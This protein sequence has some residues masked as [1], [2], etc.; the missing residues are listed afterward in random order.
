[1]VNDSTS[2]F[3]IHRVRVSAPEKRWS[4]RKDYQNSCESPA[5]W[6]PRVDASGPPRTTAEFPTQF[7][8]L[9]ERGLPDGVILER[10]CPLAETSRVLGAAY[11]DAGLALAYL[12][13]AGLPPVRLI[14]SS[15]SLRAMSEQ[16]EKSTKLL[17]V[18]GIVAAVGL[19]VFWHLKL[20]Q[21][22]NLADE[23]VLEHPTTR[24]NKAMLEVERAII[25]RK[26]DHAR[27]M[28]AKAR[29]AID[30]APS[31]SLTTPN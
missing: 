5:S 1:M 25:N 20:E 28:L 21:R 2:L 31:N 22:K 30:E 24:A 9:V 29:V 11:E 8:R 4:A 23:A 7:A 13:G 3:W 19:S 27:T 15:G 17:L 10:V 6:L 16:K 18:I 14:S 26:Y 12:N